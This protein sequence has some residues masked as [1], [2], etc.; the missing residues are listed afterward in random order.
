VS[1]LCKSVALTLLD[2]F[3]L[4]SGPA[5]HAGALRSE[6]SLRS[7]CIALPDLIMTIAMNLV[8]TLDGGIINLD[9]LMYAERT[10]EYLSCISAAYL[11][12]GRDRLSD[13]SKAKVRGE[14]GRIWQINA[15]P[16]S[17][18]FSRRQR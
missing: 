2:R 16:R 15:R 12:A 1:H 7:S 8:N 6:V 18:R 14:F 11:M 9:H 13:S 4:G 10:G 5:S 3:L 17:R